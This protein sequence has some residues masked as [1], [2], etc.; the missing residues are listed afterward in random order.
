LDLQWGITDAERM[1]RRARTQRKQGWADRWNH[2]IKDLDNDEMINIVNEIGDY[3][4]KM[5]SLGREKD[6][7]PMDEVTQM[8]LDRQTPNVPPEYSWKYF[9]EMRKKY[10][11]EEIKE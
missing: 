1:W 3:N 4:K 6:M 11:G 2:A 8:V 10:F 5:A 9:Q 7:I